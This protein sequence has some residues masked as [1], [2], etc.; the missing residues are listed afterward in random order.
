[1]VCR[2]ARYRPRRKRRPGG[3]GFGR[4]SRRWSSR[5]YHLR[6]PLRP[7]RSRCNPLAT[8]SGPRL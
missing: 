8:V 1:L 2:C 6:A 5:R 4:S 7:A 3:I